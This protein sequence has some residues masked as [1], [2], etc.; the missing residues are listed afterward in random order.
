MRFDGI[1]NQYIELYCLGYDCLETNDEWNSNWLSFQLN[2]ISN[3]KR[4]KKTKPRIIPSE[5]EW[6]IEW[7]INISENKIEKNIWM[8]FSEPFISFELINNFDSEIKIII[9][10]LTAEY[11]PIHDEETYYCLEFNATNEQ[12]RN[13]AKELENVLKDLSRTSETKR[14]KFKK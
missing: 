7:F 10:H 14:L 9:I 12:L 13:Y 11:K 2:V 5:L 1:N 4:W 3:R 8:G 6:L